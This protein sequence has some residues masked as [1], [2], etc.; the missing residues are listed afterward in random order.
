[1]KILIEARALSSSMGVATYT[2]QLVSHLLERGGHEYTVVYDHNQHRGTFPQAQEVVLP[3]TS[4][5]LLPWWLHIK[6]PR[7]LGRLNPDI[8]HFTKADMPRH[9]TRPCM[10]TI[11]D[12]IPLLLPQSQKFLQK[13]Y[14]PRALQRAAAKGHHI[15]TIS[16]TSKNDIV[17]YLNVPATKVTVTPLAA[18]TT[19]FKKAAPDEIAR[20]KSKYQLA[21]PYILFVG[22]WEPRKNIP[23]LLR[24]FNAVART[25]PH[26]L[27]LVGKKG[28]KYQAIEETLRTLP[29][30]DRVKVLAYVEYADLPALYSGSDA[31]VWPSV[32]EGWAL[33]AQEAMACGT[34]VIVS[35]G[36]ALPEVVGQAG[37]IVPFTTA[38]LPARMHDQD[39]EQQLSKAI[40]ALLLDP[41]RRQQLGEAGKAHSHTF[42]WNSVAATT[43]RE[44]EKLHQDIGAAL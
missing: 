25:I 30:R 15:M 11:Y 27:V 41:A 3:L 20:I 29:E 37:V 44:Y 34:P 24:A 17:K 7:L 1:M 4:E 12:V 42:S 9:T 28:W 39:F 10:V 31:F 21:A 23:A 8:V 5:I 14:W 16:E 6:F 2:R 18:D 26:Q 33:P 36:G 40:A 22:T 35:N 13:M 32:Y 38:D 43:L 19:H